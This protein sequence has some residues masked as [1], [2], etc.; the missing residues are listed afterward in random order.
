[1]RGPSN[2]V[3][4]SYAEELASTWRE[5]ADHLEDYGVPGYPMLLRRVADQLERAARQYWLETLTLEQAAKEAGVSYDTMQR[6]VCS[7]RVPN[8]GR[9]G[10][11]LVRRCDLLSG[12][13]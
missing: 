9:R 7:G 6:K 2:G 8:V 10:K 13:P 4:P 12:G 1:M 11:P 3:G 5:E